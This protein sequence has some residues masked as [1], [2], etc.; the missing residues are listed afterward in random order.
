[1]SKVVRS[2]VPGAW[3]SPI[4]PSFGVAAV[5]LPAGSVDATGLLGCVCTDLATGGIGINCTT[6]SQSGSL[7]W[8]SPVT[9]EVATSPRFSTAY[10]NATPHS[11]FPQ[12][13]SCP[14]PQAPPLQ[15][16]GFAQ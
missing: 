8:S 6:V 16:L 14:P 13:H 7:S 12:S 10:P 4:T 11:H 9:W 5:G 3:P 1:M 2:Y 15:R